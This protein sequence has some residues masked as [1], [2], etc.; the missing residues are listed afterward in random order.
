M[1]KAEIVRLLDLVGVKYDN[2]GNYIV[3]HDKVEILSQEI[4]AAA[5]TEFKNACIA[6]I[7]KSMQSMGINW[8]GDTQ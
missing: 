5:V 6:E 3:P 1:T 4:A 2:F 8:H 7:D